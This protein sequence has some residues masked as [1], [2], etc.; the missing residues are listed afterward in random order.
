LQS[1]FFCL[2]DPVQFPSPVVF[3]SPSLL[4][5]HEV[6]VYTPFFTYFPV[7]VLAPFQHFTNGRLSALRASINRFFF[8]L[9][10]RWFG[11][12]S[13]SPYWV[14]VVFTPNLFFPFARVRTAEES[15]DRYANWECFVLD[16]CFPSFGFF[17]I[18]DPIHTAIRFSLSGHPPFFPFR[19]LWQTHLL[20]TCRCVPLWA[21]VVPPAPPFTL[22]QSQNSFFWV[23]YGLY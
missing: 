3:L 15:V 23:V 12:L 16:S 6:G 17:F 2:A 11:M 10:P 9:G 1:F 13:F 19:V 22:A 21:G 7:W 5:V 4:H 20:K 8:G 18:F 14:S